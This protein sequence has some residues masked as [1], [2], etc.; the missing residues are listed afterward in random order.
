MRIPVFKSLVWICLLLSH[1]LVLAQDSASRIH[2]IWMGGND[3]PPC[4]YWRATELPKL[5]SSPV[6]AKIKFS[7]VVK[8]VKSGVPPGMYLDADVRPYKDKLDYANSGRGGSP[9]G[10]LLVDGE[11]F[12]YFLG[13]RTADEI[14]S[15]VN[16]VITGGKYPFRRC[17]K[18]DGSRAV[19]RCEIAA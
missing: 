12:D 4:V 19:R 14:E 8:S 5:K 7:F 13:E 10:A 6:F 1:D 16:A 11:V 15:M 3:C 2:L 18:V 17:L 9:Q